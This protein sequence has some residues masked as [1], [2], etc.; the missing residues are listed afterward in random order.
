[1]QKNQIRTARIATPARDP[2]TIPAMAPPET[3]ESSS[4]PDSEV[5]VLV[6]S[7]VTVTGSPFLSLVVVL[8]VEVVNVEDS[9]VEVVW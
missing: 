6:G 3:A 4:E 8:A 2:M 5:L 9:S 7:A 1:M